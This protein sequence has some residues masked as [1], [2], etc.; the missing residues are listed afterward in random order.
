MNKLAI[1]LFTSLL[2]LFSYAQTESPET[3]VKAC[4]E[5]L[6]GPAGESLDTAGFKALFLPEAHFMV[7]QYGKDGKTA[8]KSFSLEEFLASRDNK[9]RSQDF[10]EI[11]LG[12]AIDVYNGLAQVFQA[13]KVKQGDF[14]A[15][16]INSYQLIYHQDRWWVANIVWTSDRNGVKVPPR[17][18]EN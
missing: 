11:E 17:Y 12:K 8:Y 4:L 3:T 9:P 16:G 18:R 7:L 15:E 2:S 6:S 14:E 1:S 13:Y 5:I 10:L